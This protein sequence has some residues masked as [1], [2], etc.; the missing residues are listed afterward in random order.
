MSPEVWEPELVSR[1]PAALAAARTQLADTVESQRLRQF[2]FFRQW[3]AV[4]AHANRAGIQVIGDIPIFVAYDSADV[5]ANPGLFYLD[6]GGQSTAVA[7]VP[8]DY[9]SA[10]GQL[11]GNPLYRWDGSSKPAMRGGLNA[12][13][14]LWPLWTSSGSITSGVSKRIGK[15]PPGCP[16]RRWANGSKAG[17]RFL[18]CAAIRARRAAHHRRRCWPCATSLACRV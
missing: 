14:P 16:R 13:A 9:F 18:H 1:Q 11:W 15:Y 7:G 3:G 17:G 5:W 2:L 10:T 4:R 8:P 12:S 6:E